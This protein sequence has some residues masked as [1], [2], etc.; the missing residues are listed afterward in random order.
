[1][2]TS[3]TQGSHLFIT[4]AITFLF[5][6]G[7][8]G[9]ATVTWSGTAGDNLW[10]SAGNWVPNTAIPGTADTALFDTGGSASPITVGSQTITA[11]RFGQASETSTSTASAYQLG[12]SGT[13]GTITFTLPS[14]AGTTA[15][16]N[17][18]ISYLGSANTATE[19]IYSDLTFNSG[20]SATSGTDE[21]SITNSSGGNLTLAGTIKNLQTGASGFGLE[22]LAGVGSTITL[23][24]TTSTLPNEGKQD[25]YF[26]FDTLASPKAFGNVMITSTTALA[27]AR[28]NL[29]GSSGALQFNAG[30]GTTTNITSGQNFIFDG[31]SAENS[32][33]IEVMSGT[34]VVTSGSLNV[35][36]DNPTGETGYYLEADSG[37]YLDLVNGVGIQN[38]VS[39]GATMD[40]NLYGAGNGAV[41]QLYNAKTS[42]TDTMNLVKDGSGTWALTTVAASTNPGAMYSATST[43]TVKGGTL[44]VLA[45]GATGSS[46]VTVTGASAIL[47]GT[48]TINGSVTLASG[49]T[50]APGGAFNTTTGA[51]TSPIGSI[52]QLTLANGLTAAAGTTLALDIN[53][54]GTFSSGLGT[55]D[56]IFVTS[57]S[58]ILGSATLSVQDL[59]STVL[60]SGEYFDLVNYATGSLTGIFSGLAQ[61]AQITIG[62]NIYSIDYARADAGGTS[63]I[64]LEWVSAAAVPEPSTWAM[65]FGGLFALIAYN[66]RRFAR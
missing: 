20:N 2:K 21:Y 57:G 28:V 31:H 41:G 60:A 24:G 38:S 44:L 18:V 48:N 51:A 37:A 43:T 61:G 47:G 13:H 27:N 33:N 12:T 16:P 3:S 26:G 50:L 42:N 17:A 39:S 56:L 36:N 40:I 59:G 55:A 52:G 14:S 49:G 29:Y 63:D 64:A 58:V 53:S 7:Q 54:A 11:L 25:Y 8:G 46:A 35:G 4:F 9:A 34:V 6:V 15:A 5:L 65:M 32:P 1:M 62:Q 22:F 23:A 45:N 19:T 10:S 30:A 66:R